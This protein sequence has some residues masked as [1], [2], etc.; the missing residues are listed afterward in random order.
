MKRK[1][2]NFPVACTIAGSDSGG[3]AGIQAD[4]RTFSA[5]D[6][7]GISVLTS[8]TAQNPTSVEAV[9]PLNIEIVLAQLEA[10]FSKI[11]IDAVKTG[12]LFDSSIIN[13]TANFLSYQKK[14]KDFA[15]V[16]DP[17]MISSSGSI[18]LKNKKARRALQNRLFPLADWITPNIE[19]A[20]KILD[21]KI[22]NL[23]DCFIAV[24][25]ISERWG[26][27]CVLKGGHRIFQKGKRIDIVSCSEG[28]F[29][30]SGPDIKCSKYLAHGTGCTFSAA[31]T[32]NFAKG[33]D[34]LFSLVEA[35][36]FVH[37]SLSR[38]VNI[39][40]GIEAMFPSLKEDYSEE[41]EICR[42]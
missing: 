16:V 5:F 3:G 36:K 17:V 35:R 21:K 34:A 22:R 1:K 19:E 8:I 42:V 28:I 20:E 7:F 10:V 25:L 26:V 37:N 41:I 24:Q 9:M 18:L 23:D 29:M 30:V 32:A 14:K 27:S 31:M 4:L 38:R 6:V 15:F 13:I 39:G 2:T 11:S 12:M 40:S 33:K